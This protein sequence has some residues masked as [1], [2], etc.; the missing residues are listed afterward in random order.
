MSITA[1]KETIDQAAVDVE[2]CRGDV[3]NNA[4][5]IRNTADMLAGAWQ[6]QA[7]TSFQ[8]LMVRFDTRI[9]EIMEGLSTI[10]DTLTANGASIEDTDQSGS[11]QFGALEV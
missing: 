3:E 5:T 9:G 7:A 10:S 1:D 6:G 2:N 8:E 4:S 11:S